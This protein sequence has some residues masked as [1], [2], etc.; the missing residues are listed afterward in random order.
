MELFVLG[1]LIEIKRSVF[2]KEEVI[3]IYDCVSNLSEKQEKCIINYLFNEGI[4]QDRRIKTEVIRGE[5][6]N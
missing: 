4:I 1:Y 2:W 6:Y 3:Y 5:D